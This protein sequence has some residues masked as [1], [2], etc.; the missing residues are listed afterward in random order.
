MENILPKN[1][2]LQSYNNRLPLPSNEAY[3]V[4]T[5]QEN[6]ASDLIKIIYTNMNSVM[7]SKKLR[8]NSWVLP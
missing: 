1:K 5:T 7:D 6:M 8:Q 4:P 2:A 3:Y